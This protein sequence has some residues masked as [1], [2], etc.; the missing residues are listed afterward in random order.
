MMDNVLIKV[1][2]ISLLRES[3]MFYTDTLKIAYNLIMKDDLK[4]EF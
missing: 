4:Y 2:A 3:Y 1:K